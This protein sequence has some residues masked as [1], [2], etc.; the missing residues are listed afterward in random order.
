MIDINLSNVDAEKIYKILIT[1]LKWD[2]KGYVDSF[3]LNDDEKILLSKTITQIL[4]KLEK[5]KGS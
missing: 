1:I 5:E 3:D 4:E 2:I